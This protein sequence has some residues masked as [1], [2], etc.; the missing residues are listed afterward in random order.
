VTDKPL[1]SYCEA[2]SDCQH[3]QPT[4][5]EQSEAKPR[6]SQNNQ[7]RQKHERLHAAATLRREPGT[8]YSTAHE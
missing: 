1:K 7:K 8:D 2:E 6:R 5:L 3:F 4:M